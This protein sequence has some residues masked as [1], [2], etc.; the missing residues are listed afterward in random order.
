M[1]I[2]AFELSESEYR[3]L[4]RVGVSIATAGIR[5]L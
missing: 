2:I 4:A 3:E 5:H 1:V